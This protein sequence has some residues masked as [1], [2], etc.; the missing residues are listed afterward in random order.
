MCNPHRGRRAVVPI[1][2]V[3]LAAM[4]LGCGP[5]GPIPGGRLRGDV[6]PPPLDWSSMADVRQAQLETRPEDPHSINIWLGVVGGRLYVTSSLILGPDDPN[7]RDWVQH[8]LADPRV[9][10]RI[11]G[12]VY[13]LNAVRVQDP[14]LVE[15]VRSTM[16]DKYE[17]EPDAHSDAAW[18]FQLAPRA[19]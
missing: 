7:E 6:A 3:V 9:R 8:V 17:V 15:T 16:I 14:V 12:R 11:D 1:G 13:E 19:G 18:V 2:L 10:L 4:V 5:L